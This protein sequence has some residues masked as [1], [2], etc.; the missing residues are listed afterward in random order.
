MY[1]QQVTCQQF[2][3]VLFQFE[4][5]ALVATEGYIAAIEAMS[6]KFGLSS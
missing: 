6:L 5:S 3:S 1:I 2:E 4:V